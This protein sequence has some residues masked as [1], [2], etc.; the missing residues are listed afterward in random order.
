MSTSVLLASAHLKGPYVD[1][2][3]LSPLIALLGGAVIVETLFSIYG[4]GHYMLDAIN[5]RDY[6]VVQAGVML[7]TGLFVA[8]N[9]LADVAYAVIDP[10]VASRPA[11]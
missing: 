1:F 8:L 5:T 9:M 2:A 6:P 4:A 7:A 11:G 10:R 3:G